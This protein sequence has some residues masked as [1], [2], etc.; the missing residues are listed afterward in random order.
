M[1]HLY[2]ASELH[3]RQKGLTVRQQTR[4]PDSNSVRLEIACA[5]PVRATLRLRHPYWSTPAMAVR[6]NGA[7]I[8]AGKARHLSRPDATMA[9]WR[10]DRGR[11]APSGEARGRR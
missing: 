2:L 8:H 1:G 4:F 6:L 9:G 11:V 7:P 3:W 5:R 10:C